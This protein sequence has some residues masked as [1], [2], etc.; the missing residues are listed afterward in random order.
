MA[1]LWYQTRFKVTSSGSAP[2][3]PWQRFPMGLELGCLWWEQNPIIDIPFCHSVTSVRL[4]SEYLWSQQFHLLGDL[5]L[6]FWL[7]QPRFYCELS[8]LPPASYSV[9]E[10]QPRSLLLGR[11][12]A[13]RDSLR[14][15]ENWTMTCKVWPVRDSQLVR[16]RRTENQLVWRD[17]DGGSTVRPGEGFPELLAAIVF[18]LLPH[19]LGLACVSL[20]FGCKIYLLRKILFFFFLLALSL[21]YVYSCYLQS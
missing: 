20:P 17:G 10:S 14:L 13:T 2:G 7:W 6:Q 18:G 16:G 8:S 4:F 21:V 5:A 3:F 1:E 9:T 11:G 15:C 19:C 12:L